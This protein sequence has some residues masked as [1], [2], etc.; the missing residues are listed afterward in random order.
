MDWN[1]RR[2]QEWRDPKMSLKPSLTHSH[3]LSDTTFN[4]QLPRRWL[5]GS[6][7]GVLNTPLNTQLEHPKEEWASETR[8]GQSD[9]RESPT[10]TLRVQ[11]TAGPKLMGPKILR[12][13][14]QP[15]VGVKT[16]M[17]EQP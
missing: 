5:D 3:L 16:P 10:Y 12:R 15:P 14:S 1:L 8:S 6:A 17:G 13:I 9:L 4:Y 7:G 2:S 11:P